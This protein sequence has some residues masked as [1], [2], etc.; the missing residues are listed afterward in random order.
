MTVGTLFY[1]SS[2]IFRHIF[3]MIHTMLNKSEEKTTN[4]PFSHK[5][6]LLKNSLKSLSDFAV[7]ECLSVNGPVPLFVVLPFGDPHFLERVEWGEDTSSNPGGVKP[8]LGRWNS[9]LDV[10]GRELLYFG[11]ESITE[12]FEKGWTTW[13]KF[14]NT[15]FILG[16]I[17]LF[18]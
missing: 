2:I 5:I 1:Q 7:L 8:L 15:Y 13:N 17:I 6:I 12:A 10:F 4:A 9:D 3:G 11:Q 14:H 18:C 16:K